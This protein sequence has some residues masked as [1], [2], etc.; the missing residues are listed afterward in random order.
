MEESVNVPWLD[1]WRVFDVDGRSV[2]AHERQIRSLIR[3]HLG[4]DCADFFAVPGTD[5]EGATRWRSVDGRTLSPV[6]RHPASARL[7]EIGAGQI[8]KIEELA[9]RLEA[10][11]D[12]GRLAARV[13]RSALVTPEG[14]EALY[15]DG[16]RP[17]LALWGVVAPGQELPE[18]PGPVTVA[19]AAIS[20]PAG[21]P[22]ISAGGADGE[23]RAGPRSGYRLLWPWALPLAL[24]VATAVLFWKAS[25]PLPPAIVEIIPPA[26]PAPDPTF[27][28]AGRIASLERAIA[29]TELALPR[30]AAVCVAPEPVPDL[31]AAPGCPSGQVARPPREIMIVLDASASMKYSIA[32]PAALE[33]RLMAARRIG[34]AKKIQAQILRIPGEQR[35]TIA[36]KIL[37]SAISAAP[38]EVSIGLIS[39]HNCTNIRSHGV[40]SNLERGRLYRALARVKPTKR[41]ALARAITKAAGEISG[42]KSADDP[43]NMVLVSDGLDVCGGDP[44]AAARKAKR[45]RPGLVINVID[46][47]GHQALSCVATETGGVYLRRDETMDIDDLARATRE[48]AGIGVGAC[49]PAPGAAD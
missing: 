44:C 26:A 38:P 31:A 29:E 11:G 40:F 6:S 20:A 21:A 1:R 12:A 25:S 16:E 30:F 14:A 24:A 41:T 47:A 33:R 35:M 3:T 45:A 34:Q 28:L 17:I 27:G 15:T 13:L 46:L 37:K 18:P 2:H 22:E 43:V 48:A 36:R 9:G 32:T 49:R 5:A 4:Q 10:Q 8:A 23:K 19:A 42:G 39:F 7:S